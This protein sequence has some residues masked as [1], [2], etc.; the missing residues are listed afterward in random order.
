MQGAQGLVW[1]RGVSTC[2]RVRV[3]DDGM[4]AGGHGDPF[5]RCRRLGCKERVCAQ[6]QRRLPARVKYKRVREV[7]SL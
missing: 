4:R 1:E 3:R 6:L 5:S 2:Q 7:A